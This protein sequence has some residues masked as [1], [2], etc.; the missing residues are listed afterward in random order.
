MRAHAVPL[1]R[2]PGPVFDTCGTG[3]DR[4]GTLQ[5]L[6]GAALVVAACGVRVAKHG[7]RSVSSQCGSA[8]V[9]RGARRQR[10]AP[11]AVVERC[12]A[13]AGIAFFFAPTF[14]PSM[15]HAAPG[16]QG[17]RRAHGVQPARPADQPGAADAPARRRA[18]ARAHR[19]ARPLAA[20]ARLRA[21]L[22]RARRRRPR[23]ALDDRLHEGVGVPRRRGEH[24]LR[25]PGRLRPAEGARPARCAGGDAATN[26]A[27]HRAACW[28]ASA[29]RRATSCCSTPARRCSSPASRPRCEPASR[30][31]RRPSTAARRARRWS[32]LGRWPRGRRGAPR[33][34]RASRSAADDRRRD[35][36]ARGQR[37]GAGVRGARSK[38]GRG[39]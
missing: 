28:R 19:A 4:S 37:A 36:G 3:G 35:A 25:A 11:P 22:G 14:H 34:R 27:H 30:A 29:G 32:R 7:N 9:L 13:E 23:R 38:R 39:R 24:V 6:D 10:R 15:R 21:R 20:A 12:L 18:A 17:A 2:E 5:H 26:A 31:R 8:D 1:S 33:E 16:A